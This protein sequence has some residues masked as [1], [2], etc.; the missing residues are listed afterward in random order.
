[1]PLLAELVGL[2]P[3]WAV[4]DLGSG[5]GI[6]CVPFLDHG[7]TVYGIEPND[8]M[9][10]AAEALLSERRDFH[11][12]AES[13]EATGLPE[14]SVDLVL[15]AQAFHWFDRDA[16]RAECLRILCPPGWA[17]LVWN[18]R[19]SD[20]DAFAA[21]YERLL[22]CFGTDYATYRSE[23]IDADSLKDFFGTPPV[24][25]DL[26]YHQVLD[27]EGVRGRLLSSSYAPNVGHPDHEPMLAELRRLFDAHAEDGRIRVDYATQLFVGALG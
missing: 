13:A 22:E 16:A 27:F 14:A 4:A 26:T 19:R 1:V 15:S 6:S 21:G 24:Q 25:R 9:R 18:V 12:V 17:A 3:D 11:S 20:T 10:A 8:E 23:R 7:N 2:A 5:T